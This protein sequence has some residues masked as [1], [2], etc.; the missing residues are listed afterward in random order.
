M[1]LEKIENIALWAKDISIQ[2]VPKDLMTRTTVVRKLLK[3]Q[4][5]IIDQFYE[6]AYM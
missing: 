1:H 5:W 3:G 2:Q 4:R 6:Q